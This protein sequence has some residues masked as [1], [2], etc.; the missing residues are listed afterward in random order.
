MRKFVD[1]K[2]VQAKSYYNDRFFKAPPVARSNPEDDEI[3]SSDLKA[4]KKAKI[5][6]TEVYVEAGQLVIWI[7]PGKNRDTLKALKEIGYDFLSE[8]SAVD[9]LAERGEF[10]I[11]YQM[12]SMSKRKRL[13]VK[14]IIKEGV[15]IETVCDI[16]K[17]ADWAEREMYDMFGIVVNNH[18][19]LKRLIMPDDWHGHPLLKTYPLIGDEEAQWYEIDTI[20]GKEYRDVVGPENRDTKFVDPKDTKHFARVR[21]EVPYGAKPSSK[22]TDFSKLQEEDGVFLIEDMNK[23]PR[24]LKDRK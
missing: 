7:K 6:P 15:A 16:F 4:L 9:F 19:Y 23:E 8:M 21:H 2:N 22:P 13:R 14:T 17:S 18:P 24:I 20:F 10:E 3:F 5:K 12:L 11:F 1:K